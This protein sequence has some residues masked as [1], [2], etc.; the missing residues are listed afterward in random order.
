MASLLVWARRPL[1]LVLVLHPQQQQQQ[2][3]WFYSH[4][5]LP[6]CA[7]T[8]TALSRPCLPSLL[9]PS[10]NA[11]AAS[12]AHQRPVP[13]ATIRVLLDRLSLPIGPVFPY[14][15]PRSICTPPSPSG[16]TSS[17]FAFATVSAKPP[18]TTLSST[19]PSQAF[20]ALSASLFAAKNNVAGDKQSQQGPATSPLA[21][22]EKEYEA[23]ENDVDDELAFLR[24]GL[25]S[26]PDL[27]SLQWR[28]KRRTSF[29]FHSSKDKGSMLAFDPE[30]LAGTRRD[31]QMSKSD[32]GNMFAITDLSG[33][34]NERSSASSF[35]GTGV[36][37]H[38]T[39]RARMRFFTLQVYIHT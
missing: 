23:E 8:S 7:R 34:G 33:R 18:S 13:A 31:I 15:R 36:S 25:F 32:G 30:E 12:C 17:P 1:Q 38:A 16:Q 3:R 14:R 24:N 35:I 10:S 29:F 27:Q 22:E 2:Q 4:S 39:L 5:R 19:T 6:A 21:Q 26:A 37:F 20:S 11:A 9:S 28:E